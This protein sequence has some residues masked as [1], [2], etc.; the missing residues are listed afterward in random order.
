MKDIWRESAKRADIEREK[1][2]R[3]I[4]DYK[5]V[6][7][8]RKWIRIVIVIL[9]SKKGIHLNHVAGKNSY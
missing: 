9:C 3:I 2:D 4:E 6:S 1:R 5:K 7:D 8:N